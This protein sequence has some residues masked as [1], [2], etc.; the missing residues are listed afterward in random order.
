MEGVR[1]VEFGF[2]A[3]A[4]GAPGASDKEF[5]EGILSDCEL[6]RSLGYSTAWVLEHHFSDYYPTPDPMLLLAHISAR[7]PELALGTCVIV[8]PWHNPLRLAGQIAMM[9]TLSDRTLQLGLGRGT[10]KFEYDSYGL[11]MSEARDRFKETY[12]I[13]Q[14][15]L[16]GEPFMYQGRYLQVPKE[17]RVRPT[18]RRQGIK[19]YGAIGSPSSAAIYGAMDLPPMCTSVGDYEKQAETLQNW[20]Q[21]AE[22]AGFDTSGTTFPIMIDCI[23]AD[24]DEEAIE[25]ACL[26]KPRFMQA[27]ID[28]YTPYVTDW[29]N[30][31]GY[32]AWKRIWE[33]INA[34]TKPEGIV[35][36]TDWQL[37]G[38]PE[39]VRA[40]TQKFVE[41]GF[42]HIICLFATPGIPVDV[43][44]EWARRFAEE[45]APSFS[46]PS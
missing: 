26:Y 46:S 32:E 15:A 30:T 8:T 27:Q 44:Q 35:P 17:I 43:R 10:A 33:G 38:S 9:S 37:I 16:A 45:V 25:Q 21:A 12:E 1:D 13:L 11:D 31:P 3:S 40:K 22:A 42:N 7:F 5:Y 18:P 20:K 24:T 2:V 29:E 36:W 4:A 23:V 41:A 19:F 34:R 28:H 14:L 6:N 39:T